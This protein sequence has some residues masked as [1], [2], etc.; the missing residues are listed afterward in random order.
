M[1]MPITPPPCPKKG[2]LKY[3]LLKGLKG[4]L[5]LIVKKFEINLIRIINF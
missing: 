1:Y 2:V 4:D 5:K 3:L